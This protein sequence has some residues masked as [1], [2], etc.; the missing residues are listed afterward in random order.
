MPAYNAEKYISEAIESIL[1]QTFR[2][3][4]FIIINDASTDK[5]LDIIQEYA[6]K[7]D[8]VIFLSNKENLK[9]SKTLNEGLAIARGEYVVR[10]DADD[11]SYPERLEKQTLFMDK[12]RDVVLS[13][14][15]IQICDSGLKTLNKRE[16]PQ[17]NEDIRKKI[18]R[19]NPF[20]HPATIWRTDIMKQVGGYDNNIPLTQDYELEFKVGRY[21]K[22]ANQSMVLHR[23]RTH[24][25]SSSIRHGERQELTALYIRLKATMEYGYSMSIFEKFYLAIQFV[26]IFFV[27]VQVKFWIFNFFR[28]S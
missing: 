14:S 26:S 5:T 20:C 11:W 8:R 28:K 15:A 2:D 19:Y 4:E 22:F 7:D 12:N 18:F 27:P 21:G 16:Y 6:K 9:T 17:T 3:F 24:K 1:N 25:K 10:M 13:G 23:L